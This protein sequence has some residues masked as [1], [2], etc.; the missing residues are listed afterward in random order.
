MRWKQLDYLANIRRSSGFCAAGMLS[1]TCLSCSDRLVSCVSVILLLSG[2]SPPGSSSALECSILGLVNVMSSLLAAH[3]QRT[4]GQ[5]LTT[6]CFTSWEDRNEGGPTWWT[7]TKSARGA[8]APASRSGGQRKLFIP[9]SR[10]I[11]TGRHQKANISVQLDKQAVL[12]HPHHHLN[13]L[14]LLRNR[15]TNW[16][17]V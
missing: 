11:F 15:S 8:E 13:Q 7:N 10:L 9:Q 6:I 4:N 3:A 2:E 16:I 1:K 17:I 12:E 5:R 14:G